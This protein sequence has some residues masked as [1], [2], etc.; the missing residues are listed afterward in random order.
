MNRL[1]LSILLLLN[2]FVSTVWSTGWLIDLK[3]G[4]HRAANKIANKYNL[5]NRGNVSKIYILYADHI[6]V[7]CLS[8]KSI[9]LNFK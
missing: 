7:S 1:E 2:V 6:F 4:G 5:V 9:R 3:H 8:F